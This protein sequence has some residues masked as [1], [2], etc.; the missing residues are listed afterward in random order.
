VLAITENR[1]A[2]ARFGKGDPEKLRQYLMMVAAFLEGQN[3]HTKRSYKTAISQFFELFQWISP[4]DVTVAH[5][6]AFKKL[7]L[8]RDLSDATVYQRLAALS[9]FFGFLCLAPDGKSAPL[10]N[11]NPFTKI[12]RKD[13]VPTPYARSTPM[14][15]EDFE[16]ML[17]ALP[18]T[19][20]GIRDRAVLIFLA[21]TARRRFEVAALRVRDLRISSKE[22]TYTVKTKGGMVRTFEMPDLCYDAIKAYWISS[23]RL[24]HLTP[25]SGVF[26]QMPTLGNGFSAPDDPLSPSTISNIFHRSAALADIDTQAMGLSVH[27]VRHMTARDLDEAGISLQDIQAILG[28]SSPL[29]TQIYLGRLTGTAIAHTDALIKVRAHAREL[30]KSLS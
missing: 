22:K 18:S 25:E 23:G 20:I 19:P 21:F 30:A 27:S 15:W 4:E 7:L 8:E 9:S 16:R 10:L 28:H 24:S 13:I 14:E 26:S 6:A 2:L 1:A 11:S 5:A 12:P 3:K 17:E 29:T